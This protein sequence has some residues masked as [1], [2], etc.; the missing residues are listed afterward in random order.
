MEKRKRFANEVEAS[1]RLHR[2]RAT[3]PS[4]LASSEAIASLAYAGVKPLAKYTR[5]HPVQL[6]SSQAGEADG[7]VLG[8]VSV[9]GA[10]NLFRYPFTFLVS[11]FG[12]EAAH[13]RYATSFL[14]SY[15]STRN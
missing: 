2:V 9:R 14:R 13:L 10:D 15:G 5:P 8:W 1:T 6:R 7:R 12:S 3:Q 4:C 11:T